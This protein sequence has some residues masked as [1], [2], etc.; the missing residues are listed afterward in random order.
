SGD[1]RAPTARRAGAPGHLEGVGGGEAGGPAGIGQRILGPHDRPAG[2]PQLRG[3][4]RDGARVPRYGPLPRVRPELRLVSG[5]ADRV[6][7]R[8]SCDVRSGNRPEP[9]GR[10][11]LREALRVRR[12]RI[13]RP[14]R[15]AGTDGVPPGPCAQRHGDCG[16]DRVSQAAAVH[17]QAAYSPVLLPGATG[18]A[19]PPAFWDPATA[20][21]PLATA[22]TAG[23][24]SRTRTNP[25]EAA[26]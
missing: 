2:R 22:G 16:R 6:L 25:R 8:G 18:P 15:G 9:T 23:S 21:T 17:R 4:A 5:A 1:L 14:R 10:G 7:G 24:L 11:R 12:T 19:S 3:D 26:P 13:R 20:G